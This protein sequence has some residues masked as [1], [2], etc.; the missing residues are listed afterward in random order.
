MNQY[1]LNTKTQDF[2]NKNLTTDIS[3]L[4]FK[5]SSFENITIQELVEQIESKNKCASKL[6]SWYEVE[7]IYYPN[8]LNI[9]QTSSE[10]T[11][12]YKVKLLSGN[13]IIDLTGGFGVDCFAFSSNFKKVTHCEINGDLSAIAKHNFNVLG[14]QNI[15]CIAKDGIAYLQQNKQQFDW[16]YIDPSRRNDTKGKVF[17]LEDCLPNIPLN[18][19]LLFKHTANILIKTSPMLDISSAINELN[20]VKEVHVIAIKNEVK[21]VLYLLERDYKDKISFK[22][23]NF[24]KQ[25]HQIFDFNTNTNEANYALPQQ[26]LYEPNAAILKAGAFNQVSLQL[27]LYKLHKH[28]HL[29]TSSELID[30]PGRRFKILDTIPYQLKKLTTL[31]S[32]KKANITTRNFPESVA[33]IRKKTK[34]K[35]GGDTYLFFTTTM[36]GDKVVIVCEKQFLSN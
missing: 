25:E 31:I 2:I 35:D 14:K 10:I 21:E 30:F 11:A 17:L 18:L 33:Q 13:T 32:N 34:L 9:E 1:I 24:T 22:T 27:K 5:G 20:F 6:Q 16:I 26:Y 23:I 7:N 36:D 8:K 3:K 4:L 29:Y 19:K 15:D 12:N 28:S